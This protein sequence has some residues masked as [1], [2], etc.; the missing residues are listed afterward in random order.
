MKLYIGIL[1]EKGLCL[2]MCLCVTSFLLYNE[3]AR[4]I[5][6]FS[7]LLPTVWRLFISDRVRA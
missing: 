6:K 1:K 3:P 2:S 4:H 5:F 7:E